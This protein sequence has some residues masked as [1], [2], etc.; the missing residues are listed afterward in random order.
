M[1]SCEVTLKFDDVKPRL[2][3]VPWEPIE[4]V[5]LVM[6]Y[7]ALKYTAEN[8]KTSDG[9]PEIEKRFWG[10]LLRHIS[11]IKQGE[12]FDSDTGLHHLAHIACNAFFLIWFK[13]K[14]LTTLKNNPELMERWR[15]SAVEKY[16]EAREAEGLVDGIFT[17]VSVDV[18]P[19]TS[20]IVATQ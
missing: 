16:V 4:Q 1:G 14:E 10:A 11:D 18:S 7:G 9:D 13:R 6:T 8:W 20:D 5:A 2:E 3:L 12:K 15:E 17:A 19:S